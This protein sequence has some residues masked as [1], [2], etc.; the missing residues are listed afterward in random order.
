MERGSRRL[1]LD[2]ASRKPVPNSVFISFANNEQAV[3][4]LLYDELVK[5]QARQVQVDWDA[6]DALLLDPDAAKTAEHTTRGLIRDADVFA[7]ILGKTI[8]SRQT[9]EVAIA[10]EYYKHVVVLVFDNPGSNASVPSRLIQL[11]WVF[12]R[13]KDDVGST[14][15][16][17]VSELQQ[18]MPL[19]LGRLDH[20]SGH[21]TQH[22]AL[23]GKAL[24]WEQGSHAMTLLLPFSEQKRARD[25]LDQCAKG[26][27]PCASS[28]VRYYIR[29]EPPCMRGPVSLNNA[30]LTS[31]FQPS[32]TSN[33]ASMYIAYAKGDSELVQRVHDFYKFDVLKEARSIY[34]DWTAFGKRGSLSQEPSAHEEQEAMACSEDN[35]R[36]ARDAIERSDVFVVVMSPHILGGPD[37]GSVSANRFLLDLAHASKC[38][39][40]TVVLQVEDINFARSPPSLTEHNSGIRWV[41]CRKSRKGE[42][43]EAAMRELTNFVDH[44]L[45]HLKNHTALLSK[46]LEWSVKDRDPELTMGGEKMQE[47]RAWLDD[48]A[49]GMKPSATT[50]QFE[51]IQT[52]N[53]GAGCLCAV[54]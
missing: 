52:Q 43:F 37:S 22:T 33:P 48:C 20:A 47:A 1:S 31:D 2:G 45:E 28:V 14:T 24:E 10:F 26:Q 7:I 19:V 40:R 49:I 5:D 34:I 25:W 50:L 4:K 46:A 6:S 42:T 35:L 54:S 17:N 13:S 36:R 39:K 12:L 3:T 16:Y 18:F 32:E 8:T 38:G 41:C 29:R 11:D 53:H 30:Q 23:L 51:F 15:E 27:Q 21:V 9:L 44:D